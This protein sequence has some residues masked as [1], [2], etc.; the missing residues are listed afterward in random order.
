M[1]F[2]RLPVIVGAL[3]ITLT[4]G[5]TAD[6]TQVMSDL[7]WIVNQ[8]NA[9]AAPLLNTALTNSNNNFTVIQSG[10][11]ATQPANFP[12]AS[13]VQNN[14][15][16]ALSSTLGTNAITTRVAALTLSAYVGGQVFT[17]VP[18]Q[19]N[20]GDVTNAI[21]GLPAKHFLNAGSAL[22]GGELRPLIPMSFYYDSARDAFPLLN[23]TPYVKGPNVASAATLNL[24]AVEGDYNQV[25]GTVGIS[26][27]TLSRGRQ[28]LLEFTSSPVITNG[29]SLILPSSRNFPAGP[30][31]MLLVRGEAGGVVRGAVFPSKNLTAFVGGAEVLLCPAKSAANSA[32][33]SFTTADFDWAAFDIYR[34]EIVDLLPAS[35]GVPLDGRVSTDGSTFIS[36]ANYV[37]AY[38]GETSATVAS[39]SGATGQ[40]G[41]VIHPLV[42][43]S[44]AGGGVSG[45]AVMTR[46]AGA[47]N[48]KL[49]GQMAAFDGT[50]YRMQN[51]MGVYAGD[52]SP[53]LGIQFFF[54]TG[55]ATS[56][57]IYAYGIKKT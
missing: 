54:G 16:N 1:K 31:D 5:T 44:G 23:G 4:N 32:A 22:S 26:A 25:D 46:P 17:F 20:S 13:Q 47:T 18:S 11:A 28:H 55:N 52:Q 42:G 7:N 57:T 49:Q 29:A 34:F 50:D 45:H 37:Y 9:N 12:I 43:N 3:P 40:T 24:D 53:I 8:V 48:K 36:S 39:N 56:G 38:T 51:F 27:I 21:D 33:I 19:I 35:N 30:G 2:F 14:S 15:F 10:Q 41:F 6:A